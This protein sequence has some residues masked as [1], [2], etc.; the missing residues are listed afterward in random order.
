MSSK[1]HAT[2]E[3]AG[4]RGWMMRDRMQVMAAILVAGLFL[5]QAFLT[6]FFLRLIS[7]FRTACESELSFDG[8]VT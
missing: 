1:L 3:S 2:Q 5:E 8:L 6:C 4:M 7:A